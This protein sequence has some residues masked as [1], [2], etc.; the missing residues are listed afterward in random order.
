MMK[1][2]DKEELKNLFI[3]GLEQEDIKERKE[4]KKKKIESEKS[5]RRKKP[6]NKKQENF[7]EDTRRV[8]RRE[9]FRKI[10]VKCNKCGKVEKVHPGL[11]F[12]E[13]ET[14]EYRYKC[15][16]CSCMPS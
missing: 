5:N 14:R 9:P 3:G 1:T 7:D 8:K 10:D 6:K 13:P 15:N 16:S 11:V 2:L 12:R 4:R